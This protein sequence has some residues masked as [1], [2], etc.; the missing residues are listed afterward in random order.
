MSA[1]G[2]KQ[3]VIYARVS[4][5][6]QSTVGDGIRSQETRCR[7]F[8][9]MKN[10][11]VVGVFEDDVS[12]SLVDRPG[13]KQM[14]AYIR[15]RKNAGLIVIIDDVTRLARGV[16]TH[17]ELRAAI[18]KAGGKLESPSTEFG[19]DS[20][21]LLV[22]HL[23]ASVSQHQR[24]KNGE[25]T[26]NRMKARLQNG[27]A[28]FPAPVGYR[29]ASVSGRGKMLVRNEPVASIIQE[30]LEGFASGRFETQAQ[31]MRF[32]QDE[33]L[34]PKDGKGSVT[35]QRTYIVL[36]NIHYAGYVEAPEWGVTRRKGHH[37]PLISLE[38]YEQIQN[39][40]HGVNRA[41]KRANLRE[42][43]VLRGFVTCADCN[44]PLTSCWSK[45]SHA[46]Y[47]YY[48]CPKKGCASYGKSIRRAKIEGEF[49][50][51]LQSVTPTEKL[52]K[53]ASLMF[54]DLWD[55]RASLA[56][57]QAKALS[58]QVSKIEKQ[59]AQFLD[60]IVESNV[61][62]V[63]SAYEEK[64]AKLEH[65]KLVIREK[66]GKDTRPHASFDATLRTALEFLGNPQKLWAS[67]H[68]KDKQTV[69]KLAFAGKLAYARNE[70]FSTVNLSLPF[71]WLGQN[72]GGKLEMAHP[73]GFEPVTF[74]FG[75]QH[76]IQLS[77]GC[78]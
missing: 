21:S 67:E 25:Q 41:P 47:P 60:R 12:G 68:L 22:E 9:R 57:E 69:L 49:E 15:K 37:E 17:L 55:R 64:V 36:N 54:K 31:V 35:N 74:G 26:K 30:A 59:V 16:Q 77:Y 75:G 46:R 33:P 6:K 78:R 48:L 61:P 43:F 62:S 8:A 23:L 34:F 19:E 56:K 50:T 3:A 28:V 11:E 32:F 1:T 7:E 2:Q 73:T 58:A 45:G 20:D 5:I 39:R 38:T 71:K 40:L 24:Q 52:F 27:Y 14:L 18:A 4:S 70:G 63:I 44:G 42:D 66:L 76:S 51:L 10:Y 72:S 13:M 53:V 29:Y 65:E